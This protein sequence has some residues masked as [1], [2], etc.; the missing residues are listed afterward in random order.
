MLIWTM[1]LSN[2]FSSSLLPFPFNVSL[3]DV[4]DCLLFWIAILSLIFPLMCC[5]LQLMTV[6]LVSLLPPVSGKMSPFDL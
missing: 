2:L 3:A 1:C 6:L 5:F 4:F